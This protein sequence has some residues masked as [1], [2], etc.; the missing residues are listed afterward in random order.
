VREVVGAWEGTRI[1]ITVLPSL[2]SPLHQLYEPYC[3]P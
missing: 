1:V 2:R 3:K